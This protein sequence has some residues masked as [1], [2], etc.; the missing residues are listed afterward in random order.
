MVWTPQ[1][2]AFC[3]IEFAIT[4][5]PKDVQIAYC[6]RFNLTGRARTNV[7]SPKSIKRWLEE[8]RERG[9]SERKKKVST[10]WVRT[11]ENEAAI[12]E[13][14]RENPT[15]SVRSAAKL[16]IEQEDEES[17]QVEVK[18][19]PSRSTIRQV[20]KAHKF[21]PYKLQWHHQLLPIHHATRLQHATSQLDLIDASP[22][23]LQ[24]LLFSDE[25]HFQLHGHVNH[26]NFRYYSDTNPHW[27]REEPLHSPRLTVWAA[28]GKNGVVGPIFTRANITSASYLAMLQT[29]FLPVVQQWPSFDLLTLMQDG[30]PP[31]WALIVRAWLDEHFNGRWMGRGSPVNTAPFAWPPYSPDLT[32]CDFF[33]WGYIKDQVYR[34][35]PV[36]LDDLEARIRH[37][38]EILPQDMIDRSIDG[39]VHR[40]EKC[41]EVNGQNVE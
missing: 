37:E 2:K 16:T 40:L 26:H 38:F 14:F 41:L 21:H 6:K 33:L 15:V 39:Y 27:Y 22:D 18:R 12:V 36:N 17:N 4:G 7:P 1:Q 19:F 8:Y 20:L 23:F 30:A 10:K 35:L 29:E 9:T 25:A 32:P 24:N 5:S 11:E 13:F 3:V 31:H 34:T 28:I